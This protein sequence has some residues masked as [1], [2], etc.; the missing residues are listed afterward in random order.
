MGRQ[1]GSVHGG[2]ALA[3]LQH[4]A[5]GEPGSS[6]V[7]W[8]GMDDDDADD[9]V[10]RKRRWRSHFGERRRQTK[11]KESKEKQKESEER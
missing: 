9:D 1:D 4:P 8:H 7:A 3:P 10:V 6:G 2:Q 11:A 5:S